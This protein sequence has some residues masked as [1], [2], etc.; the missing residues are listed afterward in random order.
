MG[1]W[2]A[3]DREMRRA[4][5]MRAAVSRSCMFSTGSAPDDNPFLPSFAKSGFTALLR[6]SSSARRCRISM[7]R[8][9][10][11]GA[12]ISIRSWSREMKRQGMDMFPQSWIRCGYP[13]S[14]GAASRRSIRPANPPARGWASTAPSG[15]HQNGS[16]PSLISIFPLSVKSAVLSMSPGSSSRLPEERKWR[17]A[18][19]SR[20]Q[21]KGSPARL[22]TSVMLSRPASSSRPLRITPLPQIGTASAR[23]GTSSLPAWITRTTWSSSRSRIFS[24]E[25]TLQAPVETSLQKGF[26]QSPIPGAGAG[27]HG[28]LP[29]SVLGNSGGHPRPEDQQGQSRCARLHGS[30]HRTALR[31]NRRTIR[32]ADMSADSIVVRKPVRG[33]SDRTL[34]PPTR[35]IFPF[36][37]SGQSTKGYWAGTVR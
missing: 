19:P 10:R 18:S 37:L 15:S 32:A 16:P 13:S 3:R 24:P 4:S 31:S 27:L 2:P 36:P 12:S 5:S 35:T 33:L 17:D 30:I 20:E 8:L 1:G 21:V 6:S 9:P 34:L 14:P 22:E 28:V 26:L 11:Q 25:R 29:R 23:A 7:E